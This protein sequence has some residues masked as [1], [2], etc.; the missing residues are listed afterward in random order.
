MRTLIATALALI[1]AT[2]AA[3]QKETVAPS[4][5]PF[6]I[7]KATVEKFDPPMRSRKGG[8]SEALVLRLEANR[9]TWESLPPAS[10]T[11]LYLGTHELRPIDIQLG[12]DVVV[13]TFH[14]PDWQKLQGGEPMVLTTDHD[15]P[16]NNPGKY[17]GHPRFDPKIIGEN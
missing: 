13:I 14:D 11:F 17:A 9:A 2:T 16:I 3:A 8:Y 7:I 12:K 1:L 15:E 6:K 10:E 5:L 4:E